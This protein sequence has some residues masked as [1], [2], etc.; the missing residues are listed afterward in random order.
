VSLNNGKTA[1][2]HSGRFV[3]GGLF[4]PVIVGQVANRPAVLFAR[5]SRVAFS[6]LP[7][8]SR[9]SD[10]VASPTMIVGRQ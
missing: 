3:P 1:V 10:D 5:E 4:L 6:D 7:R 2:G 8:D 9:A